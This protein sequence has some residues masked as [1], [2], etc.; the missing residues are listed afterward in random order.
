MP[1]IGVAVLATGR[2]AQIHLAAL[3]AL[4]T[5]NRFREDAPFQVGKLV[6][7]GRNEEKA[8][9]LA[10]TFPDVQVQMDYDAILNDPGVHVVDNCLVNSLH[11]PTLRAAIEAGKHVYTEK[12]LTAH[13]D[14]ARRL[15]DQAVQA[16][17]HH[18]IVQ[19]M[20]FQAGPAR[21]KEILQRGELGRIF[22]VRAVFGYFVPPDLANRPAWFYQKEEAGGGIVHDMMAHFFDLL[23]YW[24]APVEQIAAV[25]GTFF[26]ERT[27]PGGERF[28]VEVED[29]G[30]VLARLRGGAIADVFASWV[31]RKHEAVPT[32]Q[33]DGEKGSLLFNF[34]RLWI[35]KSEETPLFR[36][37]PT[38]E[39][40]NNEQGWTELLLER[41]NP[42]Q[43]Q[44]RQFLEGI[45][46]RK[47]VRPD[48]NDAVRTQELIE[49]A[50]AR[51]LG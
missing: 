19:N 9:A 8:R 49:E 47:P 24:V 36:F 35:Q 26:P 44:L 11:Y 7:H 45:A 46:T 15:R 48:W 30:A 33:I 10:A 21:A 22:H 28:P 31:R 14:E 38:I 13:L 34:H 4:R 37:D 16:G 29:T 25:T 23:E 1:E 42:F 18:G 50:Y 51:T 6:V 12:P 39:Q 17:V 2:M 40:V 27:G 32:F 3:D 5:T 43:E 41:V 20:R